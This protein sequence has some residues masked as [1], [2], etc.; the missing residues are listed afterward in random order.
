MTQFA[1]KFTAYTDVLRPTATGVIVY[2]VLSLI[3]LLV[4]LVSSLQH[5][6]NVPTSWHVGSALLVLI[7]DF[8]LKLLSTSRLDTVVL[9]IFWVLV[10]LVVYLFLKAAVYFF[11]EMGQDIVQSRHY[12]QPRDR[13]PQN[14]LSQLVMH[15]F[16]RLITL[17]FLIFY[18]IW[19]IT[20]LSHGPAST[21]AIFG[22]WPTSSSG[23][24]DTVFFVT[25]CI[26]WHILTILLRIVSMRNHLFG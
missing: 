16:F 20:F 1:N 12:M 13:G 6:L 25:E 11:A 4:R 17:I 8:L 5:Y 2:V 18:L 15:G 10:G 24:C 9:S 23:I 3:T 19:M 21:I 26:A 22:H 7:N 14:E